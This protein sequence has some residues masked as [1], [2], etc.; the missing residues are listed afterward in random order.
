MKIKKMTGII[1]LI[2]VTAFVIFTKDNGDYP[3][4]NTFYTDKNNVQ[5]VVAENGESYAG[6]VGWDENED[7]TKRAV[8]LIDRNSR[9]VKELKLPKKLRDEYNSFFIGE[10]YVVARTNRLFGVGRDGKLFNLDIYNY[11]G[12]LIV[13]DNFTTVPR[14]EYIDDTFLR[15]ANMQ[16]HFEWMDKDNLLMYGPLAIYRVN[17]PEGTVE[18]VIGIEELAADWDREKYLQTDAGRVPG[19]DNF[20]YGI[21]PFKNGY[22]RENGIVFRLYDKMELNSTAYRIVRYKDGTVTQLT[23]YSTDN[24]IYYDSAT[25]EITDKL[26]AVSHNDKIPLCPGYNVVFLRGSG[27]YILQVRPEN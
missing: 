24:E 9:Q 23:D 11:K 17:I 5:I 18:K 21:I 25:G 10:E 4:G 16:Y 2:A 26:A 15:L 8:K 27:N 19:Q 12:E 14:D 22:S 1:F 7:Y 13:G 20:L 3:A 6:F